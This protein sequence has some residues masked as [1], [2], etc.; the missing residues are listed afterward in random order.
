MP[1]EYRQRY[2]KK[3]KEVIN[4]VLGK[5]KVQFDL[6]Y[7]DDF[8]KDPDYG[9]CI[10]D[11][12]KWALVFFYT[13]EQLKRIL[14][15]DHKVLQPNICEM[16]NTKEGAIKVRNYFQDASCGGYS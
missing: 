9:L 7:Q 8:T 13:K 3:Q 14:H 12:L 2:S 10:F 4:S 15:V 1:N 11:A 16:L 5:L 6:T